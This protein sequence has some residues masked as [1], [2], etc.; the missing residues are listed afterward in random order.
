MIRQSTLATCQVSE[1]VYYTSLA[2]ISERVHKRLFSL[3]FL[4]GSSRPHIIHTVKNQANVARRKL[5]EQ[6]SNLAALPANG[7][8]PMGPV[9][10]VP[11]SRSSGSF[12]AVPSTQGTPPLPLPSSHQQP[13][14]QYKPIPKGQSNSAVKQPANRQAPP[15][16]KSGNTWK[17]IVGV[18]IGVFLLVAAAFVFLVWRSRAARTIGPW[19]T[20]LSGQLQKAFVTGTSIKLCDNNYC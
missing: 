20:G 11:S 18:S 3:F 9:A 8:K 7:G 17:Y 14:S 10:P 2:G 13:E 16:T 1:K 4:A 5:V 12:R 6:S 19:K 15:G